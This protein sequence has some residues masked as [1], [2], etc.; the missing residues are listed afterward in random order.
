M[1]SAILLFTTLLMVLFAAAAGIADA[2]E[3]AVAEKWEGKGWIARP[4]VQNWLDCIKMR[5]LPTADVE[6]GHRSVSICH[7]VNIT[8]ELNRKLRW[9]PDQEQF[10]GDAEANGWLVRERRA[11]YELPR[12]G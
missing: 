2:P 9:D 8:R 3:P 12:I 4:H 10:I 5:E 11:G 1:K 6:I 7:L